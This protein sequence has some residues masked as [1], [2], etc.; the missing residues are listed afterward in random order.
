MYI[1]TYIYMYIQFVPSVAIGGVSVCIYMDRKSETPTHCIYIYTCILFIN[2]YINIYI[3]IYIYMCIQV[4]VHICIYIYVNIYIYIYIC[5]FMSYTHSYTS[6]HTEKVGQSG[7]G[8]SIYIC[9]HIEPFSGPAGLA[10]GSTWERAALQELTLEVPLEYQ[11]HAE[12]R[13]QAPLGE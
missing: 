5:I 7:G 12:I 9:I 11:E 10:L 6:L 1:D 2:V 13:T 4:H 8:A 3:Y